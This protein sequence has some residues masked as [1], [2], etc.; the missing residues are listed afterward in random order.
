MDEYYKLE[1]ESRGWKSSV[2]MCFLTARLG[3]NEILKET[4][5]KM[6]HVDM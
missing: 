2:C 4:A 5:A 3:G 1:Q 6:V